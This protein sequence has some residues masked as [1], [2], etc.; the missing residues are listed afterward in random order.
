VPRREAG[1]VIACSFS[2]QKY[3]FR[4]PTGHVLLRAFAGGAFGR[5]IFSKSDEEIKERAQKD[6]GRY[7][8]I[9]KNPLFCLLSRYPDS[10]AQYRVGHLEW[11]EKLRVQVSGHKG[12]YLAGAPYGGV[13]IPD[14]V[15]DAENQAERI[16]NGCDQ[17]REH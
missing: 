12:L 17:I 15:A 8:G 9:R 1:A 7:L 14:C 4:A 6:L 16:Y 10:M 2:S 3:P 13:G 5:E 11:M